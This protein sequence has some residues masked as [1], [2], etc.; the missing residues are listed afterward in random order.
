MWMGA[1]NL[2]PT[3]NPQRNDLS[4][5]GQRVQTVCQA[6]LNTLYLLKI[7]T[8]QSQQS[9]EVKLSLFSRWGNRGTKRLIVMVQPNNLPKETHSKMPSVVRY[10]VVLLSLRKE[11][12]RYQFHSNFSLEFFRAS[13]PEILFK[14]THIGAVLYG[15]SCLVVSTRPQVLWSFMVRVA[16][17]CFMSSSWQWKHRWNGRYLAWLGQIGVSCFPPARTL[18]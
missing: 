11:N 2:S 16:S 18:K 6:L 14:E 8:Q 4:V 1:C 7:L 3:E 17:T 13:Q 9:F 15:I 10:T 5:P 12:T